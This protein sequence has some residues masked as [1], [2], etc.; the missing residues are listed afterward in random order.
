MEHK[1]G[2]TRKLMTYDGP[3]HLKW[4]AVTDLAE[5]LGRSPEMV[6]GVVQK[7]L[8]CHG[9]RDTQKAWSPDLHEVVV[10][11]TMPTNPHAVYVPSVLA[12]N[13]LLV[14]AEGVVTDETNP[15]A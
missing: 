10:D 1:A 5:A 4:V 11:G 13:I 14:F 9:M 2:L 3:L 15:E 8:E 6:L 12:A 7:Q